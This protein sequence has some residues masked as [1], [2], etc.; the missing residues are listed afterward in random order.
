MQEHKAAQH[1]DKQQ[2]KKMIQ[3]AAQAVVTAQPQA[4]LNAELAQRIMDACA[5][6]APEEKHTA[7][8]EAILRDLGAAGGT[9]QTG[10]HA[11]KVLCRIRE[12][13]RRAAIECM[14][15][16]ARKAQGQET[17]VRQ[18]AKEMRAAL[19]RNVKGRSRP[20]LYL[21]Q[22]E[23]AVSVMRAGGQPRVNWGKAERKGE[24][25]AASRAREEAVRQYLK[26][27]GKLYGTRL[28]GEKAEQAKGQR[29]GEKEG[30]EPQ[31]VT[32]NPRV[33]T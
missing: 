22:A 23:R 15:R 3:D 10:T 33:E 4:K 31:K 30:K 28:D 2:M 5:A 13:D 11:G 8:A 26:G 17:Q 25:V 18:Q 9:P 32:T 1:Q 29:R 21:E 6:A 14:M 7:I 20:G 12:G 19:T 27:A 24:Q 16:F